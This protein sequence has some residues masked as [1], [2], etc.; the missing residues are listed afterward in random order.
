[1]REWLLRAFQKAKSLVRRAGK[2]VVRNRSELES[3]CPFT[4]NHLSSSVTHYSV[5]TVKV[6]LAS[7]YV[8]LRVVVL[9]V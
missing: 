9:G 3:V 1:M 4:S 2:N 6:C 5:V 8:S 7:P